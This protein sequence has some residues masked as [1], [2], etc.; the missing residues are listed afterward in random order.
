MQ[1]PETLPGTAAAS[2]I[3]QRAPEKPEQ[4]TVTRV[5]YYVWIAVGFIF[6]WLHFSSV[7]LYLDWRIY[8]LYFLA[9]S[10]VATRYLT[11]ERH[12][13]KRWHR[14]L[15]DGLSILFISVGVG[16]TGGIRSELWLLYFIL[17]IAETLAA[18]ARGFLITDVVAAASFVVA[19][20]PQ[21]SWL[22]H[23]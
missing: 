8:A 19:T 4:Q 14:V 12:G 23:E 1:S 22:V 13:R 6:V 9:V 3:S 18:S 15:F 17:V 11:G 20:W 21:G 10:G 7:R 2:P 16:M 5:A